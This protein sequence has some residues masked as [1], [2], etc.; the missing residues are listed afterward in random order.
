MNQISSGERWWRIE[1]WRRLYPNMQMCDLL[2]RFRPDLPQR[3]RVHE[4]RLRNVLNMRCSRTAYEHYS[5]I[6]WH[7]KGLDGKN[8][9]CA[10]RRKILGKFSADALA[11]NS[12]RG[13][14]PGLRDP[15]LGESPQNRIPLPPKS[16]QNLVRVYKGLNAKKTDEELMLRPNTTTNRVTKAPPPSRRKA[17]RHQAAAAEHAIAQIPDLVSRIQSTSQ[18]HC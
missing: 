14:V 10:T 12:S 4:Q 11:R 1:L 16:V 6:S 2:M 8:G 18:T 15:T 13:F 7:G 17:R 5:M 9:G 3:T